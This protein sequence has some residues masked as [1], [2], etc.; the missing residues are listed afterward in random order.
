MEAKRSGRNAID[1]SLTIANSSPGRAHSS[2]PR[3]PC[4]CPCSWPLWPLCSPSSST[5]SPLRME[6]EPPGKQQSS[7]PLLSKTRFPYFPPISNRQCPPPP[8]RTPCPPTSLFRSTEST[9]G[10]VEA[11]TPH[12][13]AALSGGKA[14]SRLNTGSPQPSEGHSWRQKVDEA[15]IEAGGRRLR[16]GCPSR[17]YPSSLSQRLRPTTVPSPP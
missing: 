17:R 3:V 16:R 11:V 8:P 12:R 7:S 15:L 5:F 13:G 14:P 10:L 2:H 4:P 1:S 6:M 9:K